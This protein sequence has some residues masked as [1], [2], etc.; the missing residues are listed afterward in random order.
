MKKLGVFVAGSLIGAAAALLAA[1]RPG[2]E[3]RAIVTDWATN[4]MGDNGKNITERVQVR[5]DQIVHD[6]GVVAN[7]AGV[8]AND[9]AE[10]AKATAADVASQV[11]APQFGKKAAEA[12]TD[13]ELRARIE[14]ARARIAN[15]VAENAANARQQVGGTIPSVQE[16]AKDVAGRVQETAASVKEAVKEADEVRADVAEDANA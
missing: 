12:E 14:Q 16:A 2:D 7:Q 4:A 11:Q 10:K 13:A 9:V 3:T 8:I 6:A 15:Q 5:R 1:P